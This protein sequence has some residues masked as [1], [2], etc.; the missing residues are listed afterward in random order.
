[1]KRESEKPE[2]S[3]ATAEPSPLE[4]VIIPGRCDDV[5]EWEAR[6]PLVLV[7]VGARRGCR[8]LA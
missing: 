2:M 6:R 7:R 5:G 8:G 4:V 1:M 3:A